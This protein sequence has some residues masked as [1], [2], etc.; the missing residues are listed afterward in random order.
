MAPERE[1]VAPVGCGGDHVDETVLLDKAVDE[2][3]VRAERVQLEGV[4]DAGLSIGPPDVLRKAL[5]GGVQF[6]GGLHA[7]LV[8]APEPRFRGIA[9]DV[10]NK[11]RDRDRSRTR[12]VPRK[13]PIVHEAV[14]YR[15]GLDNLGR[16]TD[17]TM[18]EL[19][20]MK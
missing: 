1:E 6:L 14:G 4:A 13:V 10:L 7:G 15:D 12:G 8:L 9:P 2:L 3:L 19:F 5:G 11:A 17:D 20:R 16:G 18:G